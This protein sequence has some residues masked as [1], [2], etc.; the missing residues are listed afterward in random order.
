MKLASCTHEVYS[1]I[2]LHHYVYRVLMPLVTQ[3]NM[4]NSCMNCPRLMTMYSLAF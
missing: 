1:D 3:T 2:D 4:T